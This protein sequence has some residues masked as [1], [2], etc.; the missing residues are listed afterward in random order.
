MREIKFRGLNKQGVWIY[1]W[2]LKDVFN[3]CYCYG[4][5]ED[6]QQPEWVKYESIG[7]FTGLKDVNG[8]D[9]Y[10]GDICRFHK[11]SFLYKNPACVIFFEGCFYFKTNDYD[12][13]S[14]QNMVSFF[15]EIEVIGNI[16][17]NPELMK[18]DL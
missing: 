3:G 13:Y 4:I 14:Y 17:Q 9:I 10:D 2:L 5:K 6:H 18:G 11:P 8:I 1:G 15:D 12:G 16:H 7:Q